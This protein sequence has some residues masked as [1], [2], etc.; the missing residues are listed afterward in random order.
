MLPRFIRI[1][2]MMLRKRIP[3]RAAV[4]SQYNRIDREQMLIRPRVIE[5]R[6]DRATGGKR[7]ENIE[8]W[9]RDGVTLPALGDHRVPDP[10]IAG[11]FCRRF[12]ESH[13][14]ALTG[15]CKLARLRAQQPSAFFEQAILETE[16]IIVQA[17]AE[18][19]PAV[20]MEVFAYRPGKVHFN[21]AVP[22][23]LRVLD[24]Y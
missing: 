12:R 19:K 3:G 23:F 10:T 16:S 14:T 2:G 24:G 15:A 5:A 20:D 1:E 4:R 13:G 6:G 17:D 11:D 9:R 18:S 7:L 22:F 21:P 8:L